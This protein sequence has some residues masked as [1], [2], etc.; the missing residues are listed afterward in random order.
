MAS[1]AQQK[2]EARERRIAEERARAERGRRRRRMQMLGGVLVVAIA[3]IAVA[4]AISVSGSKTPGGIPK[5]T[6]G[7]RNIDSSV[8]KLLAGI[9]ESGPTLGN[10]KAP[11]TLLYYG[12][13]ECPICRDFTLLGGF[14]QLITDQVRT[15]KVKVVYSPFETATPSPSTFHTQQVAGLAAGMQ[16]KFWYFTELFYHEQGAE[17]TGYVTESYLDGLAKQVPGLNF[18]K[19]LSDRQ[20]P[21]LLSQVE[22]D[23]NAG[24]K[25]G[26]QGTPTLIFT[27]PTGKRAQPSSTIPSYAELVQTIKQVS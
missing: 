16:D 9:P 13:Y 22:G 7:A 12:D 1:R 23:E 10:P 4:I 5:T 21:S 18:S 26:I 24:L 2:A 6:H 25:A 14:P 11:V 3:V 27:G 15:G 17:D 19:W 20:D 8:D